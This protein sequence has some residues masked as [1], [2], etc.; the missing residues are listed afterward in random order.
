MLG[1]KG[2]LLERSLWVC[3][4]NNNVCLMWQCMCNFNF[5]R[6]AWG[7]ELHVVSVQ[8]VSA[9]FRFFG[10]HFLKETRTERNVFYCTYFLA[11]VTPKVACSGVNRACRY[12]PLISCIVSSLCLL[13]LSIRSTIQG[14]KQMSPSYIQ[15]H[16]GN[17]SLKG[18][19]REHLTLSKEYV[20]FT[21][22]LV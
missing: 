16:K 22:K 20:V 11:C 19:T 9:W 18:S 6:R 15:Q 2:T 8:A 17:R 1:C 7:E 12:Q 13:L 5:R 3:Y 21:F 4:G 14:E 10:Q